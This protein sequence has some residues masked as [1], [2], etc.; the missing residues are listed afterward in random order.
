MVG[1][2]G[3]EGGLH[4][5]FDGLPGNQCVFTK[6]AAMCKFEEVEEEE[7]KEEEEEEEEEEEKVQ[8]H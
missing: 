3:R 5:F 4:T 6:R 7:K 8:C 2:G 1:G